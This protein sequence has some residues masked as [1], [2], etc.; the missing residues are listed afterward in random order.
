MWQSLGQ[1]VP[2][3]PESVVGDWGTISLDDLAGDV[4]HLAAVFG[5]LPLHGC[6][7]DVG[8]PGRHRRTLMPQKL[9]HDALWHVVIDHPRADRMTESVWVH[10]EQGAS[11]IAH[12]VPISQFVDCDSVA[13]RRDGTALSVGEEPRYAVF[14]PLADGTLLLLDG[15]RQ[16]ARDRD[17]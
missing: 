1:D 16:F 7:V 3:E 10:A 12:A 11:G 15:H 4:D 6:V 13:T 8:I 14:P 2:L 17:L 9:L 5:Q